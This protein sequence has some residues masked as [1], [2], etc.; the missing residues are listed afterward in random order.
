[1]KNIFKVIGIALF[2][3]FVIGCPQPKE[4]PKVT[5]G[6]IV[7][8]QSKVFCYNS[9]T[10]EHLSS[11]DMVKVGDELIFS[12][13]SEDKVAES[14]SLNGKKVSKNVEFKYTV[15]S[16]DI[17]SGVLKVSCTEREPISVKIVYE[18]TKIYM[19]RTTTP[20]K[21][22]KE[23]TILNIKT[24]GIARGKVVS[25]WTFN[26]NETKAVSCYKEES[27]YSFDYTV[28][29]KDAV[30]DAGT[31]TITIDYETTDAKKFIIEF[32]PNK[33][34][35]KVGA[36]ILNPQDPIYEFD[37]IEVKI[38]DPTKA[39]DVWNINGTEF[40]G[41]NNKKNKV[42]K[43]LLNFI[44]KENLINS[45]D[46]VIIDCIDRDFLKFKVQFDTNTIKCEK[47]TASGFEEISTGVEVIEFDELKFSTKSNQPKN[48]KVKNMKKII[49]LLLSTR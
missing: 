20:G 19:G 15:K 3:T 9:N 37:K 13:K 32:D 29:S 35:C 45:E 41:S 46:K 49:M 5:S 7:F 38:K 12:L 4:N 40:T 18:K 17:K 25:K 43:R 27:E 11:S 34:D 14:W 23:G 30:D 10:E 48:W 42:E 36:T 31:K 21:I 44:V 22:V 26:D 33:V 1:M 8:D 28:D 6:K 16:A 39:T 2:A 47:K 24:K